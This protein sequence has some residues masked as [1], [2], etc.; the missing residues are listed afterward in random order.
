MFSIANE[1]QTIYNEEKDR[2]KIIMNM[3]EI[4]TKKKNRLALSKEEISYAFTG[5]LEST[6]PDYQMSALLMAICLNG[7][8]EEETFFL[9]DLFF[10]SGETLDLSKLEGVKVDKHS[11]GGIGDKTTMIIGPIVASCGVIVPKMSGRG[12]GIT[13]GTIDKL[14]SI[15]GFKTDLSEEEFC[16]LLECNGFAVVSQTKN[17]VPMDKKIYALR[18]VTGTTESSPL[19]AAS[20]MSKKI[21]GGADKILIDIKVGEGALLKNMR[22]ALALSE[23]MKKIGAHYG[24]EVRCLLTPMDVP[25]GKAIGNRIEVLEAMS[26]LQGREN[27]SLTELCIT[28]SSH[29]VSMGKNCSFDDAKKQVIESITTGRAYQKFLDFVSSQGGN[30]SN[31]TLSSNKQT[32]L[33]PKR[34]KIVAISASRIG[35]LS[36]ILGAGRIKKDD[37]IDP[38][39]G[40]LLNHSIDDIVE[41]GDIL[42]TMYGKEN[43]PFPKIDPYYYVEIKD[44]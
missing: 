19:I 38:E 35:E 24:K 37:K 27:S 10:H 4:I 28:L 33:A 1:S 14:E 34:G 17:L 11:T 22:D 36:V 40:I 13:G 31:L 7:M 30:L 21:A 43:E 9:T 39:V 5:Y 15:P 20:I 26:V 44:I 8:N 25:L 23:T 6:I 42:F 3:V 2:V 16:H 32:V 12:L 18:D 29:M 41:K